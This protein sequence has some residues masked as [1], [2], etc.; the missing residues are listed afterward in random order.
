[1]IYKND[2]HDH[3]EEIHFI[4]TPYHV[5]LTL[6]VMLSR[7][8]KTSFTIIFSPSFINPEIYK[9]IIAAY[10]QL[11]QARII[12]INGIVSSDSLIQ[13]K[14]KYYKNIVHVKNILRRHTKYRIYYY[15][16]IRPDIQ[17]LAYY[18]NKYDSSTELILMED[19][20]G[21]YNDRVWSGKRSIL[22]CSIY[23]LIY[24]T[25]WQDVQNIGSNKY[26]KKIMSVYPEKISNLLQDKDVTNFPTKGI[27]LL[28]KHKHLWLNIVKSRN[29]KYTEVIL[30]DVLIIVDEHFLVRET[31]YI[32]YL[33]K[34]TQILSKLPLKIAIKYHPTESHS[35]YLKFESNENIYTIP[36]EYPL[37]FILLN[38][39]NEEKI[40]FGGVSG[41]LHASNWIL[42][43]CKVYSIVDRGVYRKYWWGQIIQDRVLFKKLGITTIDNL[44]VAYKT[45]ERYINKQYR[46]SQTF[47]KKK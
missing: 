6:G 42:R 16:D 34:M 20:L 28:K 14:L 10:S 11:K 17:A 23:R 27:E 35:N 43:K 22:V 37:E 40:V 44:D 7:D 30:F 1:M 41:G 24:G 32:E 33:Q 4:S 15:N 26:T 9:D 8:L 18:G 3:K 38:Q 46:S 25:W 39:N 5:F 21:L 12:M 13:R 47:G 36:Q 19:G 2:S 29:N 45:V 31:S